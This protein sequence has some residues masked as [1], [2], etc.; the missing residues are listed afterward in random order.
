MKRDDLPATKQKLVVVGNGMA[1]IRALEELLKIAPDL[2][3]V[4]VFGA[5][6][7]PNYNRILLSPVLAGEQ[8]I[9][10]IILN[11]LSWYAEQRHHAAHRQEGGE[12]RSHQASRHRRRR[13]RGAVR[14]PAAGHRL[15]PLHPAGAGQGA[16]RRHH[17][18]R[19]RRHRSDDR[20]GEVVQE[21]RRHR[22]R[23]ARPGGRERPEA[24]RHGRDR[25]PHHAVADGAPARRHRGPVAATFAR[26]ARHQ[27]RDRRQHRSADRR[28]ERPRDVRPLQGRPRDAGRPGGDG[29]R[30]PPQHHA[31]RE[32]WACIATAASS[33]TTRCRR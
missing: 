30:H 9:D 2:Y 16:A 4:T 5:E 20:C 26:S 24:A 23:P 7:H 27:V 14:P 32:P 18:P 17:L 8:T 21:G 28:Q 15:Q 29:R 11:P 31:R 33:S 3:D 22:R 19:H 10:E 1:G 13:H 25:R 6:P 12:D